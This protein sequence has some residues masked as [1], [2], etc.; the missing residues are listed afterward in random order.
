MPRS[1]HL[2]R[3]R[4]KKDSTKLSVD[5]INDL[6]WNLD[7][8]AGNDGSPHPDEEQHATLANHDTNADDTYVRSKPHRELS[9]NDSRR[10]N[11]FELT[12]PPKPAAVPIRRSSRLNQNAPAIQAS[13]DETKYRMSLIQDGSPPFVD[14]QDEEDDEEDD[15]EQEEGTGE[16][17][18]VEDQYEGNVEVK[19]SQAEGE[20][21][22][23][24]GREDEEHQPSSDSISIIS[25]SAKQLSQALDADGIR[26]TEAAFESQATVRETERVPD[27]V[28]VVVG[29]TMDTRH[30]DDDNQT[31]GRDFAQAGQDGTQQSEDEESSDE[32]YSAE[33]NESEDGQSDRDQGSFRTPPQQHG[34]RGKR[35]ADCE[36]ALEVNVVNSNGFRMSSQN[37]YMRQI[38]ETGFSTVQSTG[39]KRKAEQPVNTLASKSQRIYSQTGNA[40][41][42]SSR[43]QQTQVLADWGDEEQETRSDQAVDAPDSLFEV[44]AQVMGLR[45]SW[46]RFLDACHD[47]QT[48]NSHSTQRYLSIQS[49]QQ[50]IS[51]LRGVYKQVQRDRSAG[52]VYIDLWDDLQSQLELVRN[53]SDL[54]LS[55]TIKR[56]NAA[57]QSN[58]W[59]MKKEASALGQQI[60]VHIVTDLGDLAKECLKAHYSDSTLTDGGFTAVLN[61]LSIIYRLDSKIFSMRS[62]SLI[63]TIDVCREMRASLSSLWARLSEGEYHANRQR[64]SQPPLPRQRWTEEKEIA[65]IDG[66]REYE[67]DGLRYQYLVED[68]PDLAVHTEQELRMKAKELYDSYLEAKNIPLTWLL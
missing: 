37:G 64:T 31:D 40:A 38:Y 8:E 6:S 18:G 29:N 12:Q 1:A 53:K 47:I 60:S 33:E 62:C 19:E 45:R 5:F 26:A 48:R 63:N 9:P 39:T 59:E 10:E 2:A 55:R 17:N 7:E 35:R 24:S 42:S 56:A 52:I 57:A 36:P 50:Q 22:S 25:E 58:D 51:T 41:P 27:R 44:A 14:D 3:R 61:I 23:S 54:V 21:E 16:E 28:V 13:S 46:K 49:L 20:D 11:L 15:Q 67:G 43:V 68:Y 30:D 4:A 32:E 65:I 34:D 66:L